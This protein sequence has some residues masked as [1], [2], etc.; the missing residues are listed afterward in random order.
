MQLK[1]LQLLLLDCFRITIDNI[2]MPIYIV[3]GFLD[4]LSAILIPVVPVY[5]VTVRYLIYDIVQLSTL[6][7]RK[8][9]YRSEECY[10]IIPKIY[11]LCIRRVM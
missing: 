6:D 9:P 3:T 11:A 7:Y 2:V 8:A 5:C 10:R 1:C 4:H